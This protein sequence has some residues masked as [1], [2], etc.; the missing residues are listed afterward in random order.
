MQ[1]FDVIVLGVGGMG[2]AVC[3][4]LARRG[5]GV[6]GIEQFDLLHDRG[7]SHGRTRVIRQAYFEDPHYVPLVRRSFEFWRAL[8]RESGETLYRATGCLNLGPAEHEC[9][10]GARRSAEMH[11][12]AYEMLDRD[13]IRRRWPALEP[14]VRDVGVFEEDAGFLLP[15][16]CVAAHA[17]LAEAAGCRI[18]VRRRVLGFR[19][20]ANAVTVETDGGAYRGKALVITAGAWLGQVATE[21]QLPLHVERQVQTWFAPK[22]PAIFEAGRMP[23]FIHF[24]AER[25]YYAI[26]AHE[27]PWVKIAR[28]HG[29]LFTTPDR[30]NR[31]ISPADE[32]DIRWYIQRYLPAADGPLAD[33]K[34]C[35]Y[36][37]TPDDHFIIDRHPAHGNVF[38]AGGFSGHGFKFAPVVGEIMADLVRR[39][40]TSQPIETFSIRRFSVQ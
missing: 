18:E 26:P 24:V 30:V 15:E 7:S 10:M 8:E 11:G 34:V 2:S 40:R 16:K 37:N 12:L 23:V 29:G 25:A 3:Y 22:E 5:L 33:G 31:N 32:H 28:H 19:A 21:L 6:L 4:H 27:Q 38:I 9:V 17:R 13:E 1:T 35:L 20:E 36:T 39:G 14:D